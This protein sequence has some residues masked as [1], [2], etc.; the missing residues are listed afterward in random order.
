MQH[1]VG[2]IAR[3]HYNRLKPEDLAPPE[4]RTKWLTMRRKAYL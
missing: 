4:R 2:S 3:L 1:N